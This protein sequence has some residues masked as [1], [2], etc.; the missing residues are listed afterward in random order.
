[1]LRAVH[2][3]RRHIVVV[4]V[5]VVPSAASRDA[6]FIVIHRLYISPRDF[7]TMLPGVDTDVSL[8]SR[9][10]EYSARPL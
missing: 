4:V 10:P 3:R 9:S 7:G 5:V 8:I 2:R 1:M 6:R